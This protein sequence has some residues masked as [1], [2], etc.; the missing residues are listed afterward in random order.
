MADIVHAYSW[1]THDTQVFVALGLGRD[2]FSKL[3]LNAGETALEASFEADDVVRAF[4]YS[5]AVPDL[6]GY[7]TRSGLLALRRFGEAGTLQQVYRPP[8]VRKCNAVAFSSQGFVATALDKHRQLDSVCV[9]DTNS[10]TREPLASTA[11]ESALSAAFVPSEPS[12]LLYATGRALREFDVRARGNV[13]SVATNLALHVEINKFN[14][15]YFA[16]Y[17]DSGSV[18]LWDRRML[19][20][21]K[22]ARNNLF[23]PSLSTTPSS[24][25]LASVSS[26]Q[27]RELA[28]ESAREPLVVVPRVLAPQ[29]GVLRFSP[30]E[31][32]EFA[33]R[34]AS[35]QIRRYAAAYSDREKADTWFVSKVLDVATAD[36]VVSFDYAADLASDELVLVCI[37][38]S[39]A[40]FSTPAQEPHSSIHFDPGNSFSFLRLP[41]T[42]VEFSEYKKTSTDLATM[43]LLSSHSE[44]AGPTSGSESE[45]ESDGIGNDRHDGRQND[46]NVHAHAHM[47]AHAHMH[48]H[49][50]NHVHNTRTHMHTLTHAISIYTA[51]QSDVLAQMQRRALDGYNLNAKNNSK[52]LHH[53][54]ALRTAWRW[55][56][57]QQEDPN[58][59]DSSFDLRFS[60]VY[61]LWT[62]FT[63]ADTG[64]RAKST[65]KLGKLGKLVNQEVKS[66][67]KNAKPAAYVCVKD[68]DQLDADSLTW[69]YR[70]VCLRMCGWDFG[71]N[72]LEKRLQLL[73]DS[74]EF[75]KAAGHAVFHNNVGR[76]VESLAKS[77]RKSHR[78]M[79]TAISGYHMYKDV[80]KNN[81][82]REQCRRLASEASTPYIR[83]IFAFI[84]D[85]SWLDVIDDPSLPLT[86]RL[87]IAL[88]FLPK[89]EVTKF[90]VS[91]TTRALNSGDLEALML[92]GL[93]SRSI[94]LFQS[95]LDRTHDIQTVA[96]LSCY[97]Y[98]HYVD[99]PVFS[100]WI[101]EYKRLLNC[102]QYYTQ[103]ARLDIMRQKLVTDRMSELDRVKNISSQ[104]QG[105]LRCSHCHKLINS[106]PLGCKGVWNKCPHCNHALPPCGVCSA[107]LGPC[108]EDQEETDRWPTFCL[109]CNHGFHSVHARQ[110]FK[111]YSACPVQ[112]CSCLCGLTF[113]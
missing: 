6:V 62:G 22:N 57:K 39:G 83:A 111:R 58:L 96:L 72:E 50:H 68:E 32:N 33:C 102:W 37:R 20:P 82:W 104:S 18:A 103:R 54:H 87:G 61:T 16:S 40:V 34:H 12:A 28:R 63:T 98:P 93:T 29:E 89:L 24:A 25:S 108:L 81:I 41:Q 7:G 30:G 27:T 60:G 23:A 5:P 75:E 91:L 46:M 44:V 99:N 19:V 70:Q 3:C 77:R 73:E 65:A 56:S 1:D 10:L 76:A 43:E 45:S 113:I 9:F 67:A 112:N 55:V 80:K 13:F 110:W 101:H 8:A 48:N 36:K 105:F 11:Q 17:N 92:T 79:A 94:E 21:Q 14:D 47:Q 85:G 2:E 107:Q 100:S 74:G 53:S 71:L 109:N 42:L 52:L 26:P 86:E 35:A 31:D 90:L 15:R 49:V 97:A 4:D 69:A 84:A 51:L 66:A 64:L 78:L 88:R 38:Q 59:T 106:K 95:Y